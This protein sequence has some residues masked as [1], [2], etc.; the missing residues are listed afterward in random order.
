M[1]ML[2][3][4]RYQMKRIYFGGF[5]IRRNPITMRTLTYAINFWSQVEKLLIYLIFHRNHSFFVIFNIWTSIHFYTLPKSTRPLPVRFASL[6]VFIVTRERLRGVSLANMLHYLLIVSTCP[7]WCKREQEG[8]EP[9]RPG[10]GLV[11][12]GEQC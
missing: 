2:Y 5:F 3:G 1:A 9:H 7:V 10:K 8:R 12:L 4:N 11:S 6:W